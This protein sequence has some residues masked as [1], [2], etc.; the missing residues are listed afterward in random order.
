ML[1]RIFR[2]RLMRADRAGVDH[3][4]VNAIDAVKDRSN[5]TSPVC[6]DRAQWEA[7]IKGWG[8]GMDVAPGDGQYLYPFFSTKK[9]EAASVESL[10]AGTLTP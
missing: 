10:Q 9:T 4:C 7:I 6:G 2:G 3:L 5:P 1:A 8:H